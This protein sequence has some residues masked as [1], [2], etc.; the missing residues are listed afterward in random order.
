MRVSTRARDALG[1]PLPHGE[2]GVE[3]VSEVALPADEALAFAQQL[4]DQGRA[5]SAHEVLEAV[6]KAAPTDERDLWQGL[7]QLCV[8]V[9]HCQRGTLVGAVRL[10]RRG[11]DRLPADPPPYGIAEGLTGW[12]RDAADLLEADDPAGPLVPLLTLRR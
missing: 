3:P 9:T 2:P 7:A 5:F 11:A 6:W 4:L 12:A 1:R 8:G 10:L